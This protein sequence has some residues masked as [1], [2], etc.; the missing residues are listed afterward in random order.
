MSQAAPRSRTPSAC[1]RF[2]AEVAVAPGVER[3]AVAG[4]RADDALDLRPVVRRQR[5]QLEPGLRRHVEDQLR[6]AARGGDDGK[7]P[8]RGPALRL[9]RRDHLGEL[10]E[11]VGLDGAMGAQHLREHARV[12]G[13]PAGVARDRPLNALGAPDLQHH[14]WLARVGRAVE[15]GNEAL[16]L[17]HALKEQ[18]DD[19]GLRVVDQRLQVIAPPRP[20]PRCRRR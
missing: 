5:R 12:A 8:P 9:A 15:R 19:L 11:V 7:A 6:L 14:D 10:V 17:P 18:R 13:E 2:V 16:G 1:G 4:D 3:V 20:P